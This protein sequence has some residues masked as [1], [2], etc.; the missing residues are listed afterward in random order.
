M[1][2]YKGTNSDTH[3]SIL[4]MG[5]PWKDRY[6][7]EAKRPRIYEVKVADPTNFKP[8]TTDVSYSG[9]PDFRS[10]WGDHL[11]WT[12]LFVAFLS[13]FTSTT[14][15]SHII[16]N[17]LLLSSYNPTSFNYDELLT[18]SLNK[19]QIKRI[20]V[21]FEIYTAVTILIMFFWVKSPCGF[22]GR[23]RRFG[24][25]TQNNMH[26]IQVSVSVYVQKTSLLE[27]SVWEKASRFTK[28]CVS[29]SIRNL[30]AR[31]SQKRHDHDGHGVTH[32]R[33]N[34]QPESVC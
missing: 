30:E 22:V 7:S 19:P 17:P 15:S 11:F 10:R 27:A 1:I 6:A 18:A 28:N 8:S 12:S 31:A 29:H 34:R 32:Y 23:S 4:V 26:R 13:P 14:T 3:C 2:I 16:S 21:R 9:G 25:L 24:D 5:S 20:C 33:N